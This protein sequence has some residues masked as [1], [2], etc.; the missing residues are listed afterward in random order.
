MKG[1]RRRVRKDGEKEGTRDATMGGTEATVE[2]RK[3][4]RGKDGKKE[5]ERGKRGD[6]G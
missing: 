6:G 4:G 5:G 2:R 3:G 1:R